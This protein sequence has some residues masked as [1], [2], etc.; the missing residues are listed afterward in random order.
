MERHILQRRP[1]SLVQVQSGIVPDVR[2]VPAA[3]AGLRVADIGLLK[4]D[5]R[6]DPESEKHRQCDDRQLKSTID[7]FKKCSVVGSSLDWHDVTSKSQ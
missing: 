5:F 3:E 4:W 6:Y 2:R 1:C 7:P